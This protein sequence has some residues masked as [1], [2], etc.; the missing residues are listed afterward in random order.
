MAYALHHAH[1]RG[2]IHRDVKPSN[3]LVSAEDARHL[4]LS[5]FGIAKLQGMRGLTKS[6]TTIGTPEYMS[7]EQAEGKEIDPRADVYSL[8]CVLYEAL[9]GRP[10]FIGATPVSV[11][12]QQVHSRPAYLRG[13]NADVPRELSRLLDQALAKRPEERFG[14][15]E[16]FAEALLPFAEGA[17][18][19]ISFTRETRDTGRAAGIRASHGGAGAARRQ[20]RRTRCR[21]ASAKRVSTPSSPTAASS[22]VAGASSIRARSSAAS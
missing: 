14:T 18:P 21:R 3:M 16:R 5:D 7:P 17:L 19:P 1:V 13:L 22:L 9:S 20:R 2:I 8:G 11:L 10:P 6:G 12:Y 4:L 15:A